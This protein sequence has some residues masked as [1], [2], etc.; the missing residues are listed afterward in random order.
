MNRKGFLLAFVI[1]FSTG[2]VL[3]A[4]PVSGNGKLITKEL[5]LSDFNEIRVNGTMEFNYTQ[6]ETTPRAEITIDENLY[7]FLQV[8]VKNRILQIEFKGAKVEKVTKFIVKANS[9]WLKAVR[10]SGN[11]SFHPQNALTGD[12]MTFRGNSNCLFNLTEPIKVGKL[13]MIVRQS[14]NIV[15]ETVES[16]EIKCDMDGSG[17][18]R[19]KS[20]DAL[21]GA[22][23]ITGSGDIHAYGFE[24]PELSCKI[25]GSGTAEVY[26]TEQ[27]KASVV[28]SGTIRHKGSASVSSSIIGKGSIEKIE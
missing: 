10:L 13:E 19:L 2:I 7:P 26:A 1:I 23:S 24:I 28:G 12:E 11:A 18:I 6:S 17:S 15:A 5:S 3:A 16:E 20:G 25:T 27:L 9:Q 8:D 22:Y 14:A 21:K 4:D